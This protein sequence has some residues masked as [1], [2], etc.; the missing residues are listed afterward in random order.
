M[1][2]KRPAFSIY[3]GIL[4]FVITFFYNQPALIAEEGVTGSFG[5]NSETLEVTL[6]KGK[7]TEISAVDI[8]V[9]TNNIENGAVTS[10][11]IA[12]EAVGAFQ[13][14]DVGTAGSFTNAN[15]T[16]DENGRVTSA[17]D[18]E[19]FIDGDGHFR[20]PDSNTPTL[21]SC[22]GQVLGTDSVGTI[23]IDTPTSTCQ[24]NFATPY[25]D[26][27][28]T[29]VVSYAGLNPPNIG[30]LTFQNFT[31]SSFELRSSN[32]IQLSG[33]VNYICLGGPVIN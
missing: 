16:V 13:L 23:F 24:L 22:S 17:S 27:D 21:S 6:K 3:F 25:Q 1:G 14:E 33:L 20:T 12:E 32:A 19:S 11:K 10:D 28:P 18:G 31:N 29:C 26:S 30:A 5:S 7:V 8:L 2:S 4:I 9:S 15:I